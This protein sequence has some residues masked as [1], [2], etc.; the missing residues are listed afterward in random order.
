MGFKFGPQH[1][2]INRVGR[3]P[4]TRAVCPSLSEA[5]DARD[6]RR[7]VKLSALKRRGLATWA[8]ERELGELKRRMA[9]RDARQDR[10]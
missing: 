2:L 1:A 6:G 8:D 4:P 7:Y 9:L 10:R 5:D 3:P